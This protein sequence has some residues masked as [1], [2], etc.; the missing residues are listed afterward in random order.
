VP[1]A[2]P[3]HLPDDWSPYN[4]QLLEG[5]LYVTFAVINRDADEAAFDVPAPGHGKVVAYDLDGHIVQE[6][7]DQGRLNSPWGVAISPENFGPFGRT[8]LVANFGDGTIASFDLTTGAFRGYLRDGSRKPIT[9]DG[10]WG[11]TFGNGV[12]L[13]ETDSLYFT[14]GP[15]REQDGLFGRIRYCRNG[16]MRQ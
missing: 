13:G 7:A 3:S 2:R 14:A 12:S 6:F 15:N 5:R 11:L 9:I 10:I 1:F 4:I 16:S 8:L